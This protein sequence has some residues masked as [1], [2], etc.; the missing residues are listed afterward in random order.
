MHLTRVEN[1][2]T[3]RVSLFWH[4]LHVCMYVCTVAVRERQHR[5]LQAA[6][7]NVY[8]T[9][10]EDILPF[11]ELYQQPDDQ[12]EPQVAYK[13]SRSRRTTAVAD[14]GEEDEDEEEEDDYEDAPT[15]YPDESGQSVF[16]ADTP[17]KEV[18]DDI[19]EDSEEESNE[20]DDDAE[21]LM[22]DGAADDAH[23]N[24]NT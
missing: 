12:A 10:D 22:T 8:K 3:E 21:S 16:N 6:H 15:D 18:G 19:E 11:P 5:Y 17:I 9:F 4:K 13:R 20:E 24:N 1:S 2:D 7:R 23:S 14:T